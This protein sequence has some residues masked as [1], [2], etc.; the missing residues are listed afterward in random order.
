LRR[1]VNIGRRCVVGMRKQH[2]KQHPGVAVSLS[3]GRGQG[4]QC[5]KGCSQEPSSESSLFLNTSFSSAE[6]Y[7]ASWHET[8]EQGKEYVPGYVM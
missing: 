8:V 7:H 3:H 1:F 4:S 2:W 6:E 5:L